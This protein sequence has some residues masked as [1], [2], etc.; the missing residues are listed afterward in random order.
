MTSADEAKQRILAANAAAARA[1]R[2]R[3]ERSG[4]LVVNLISSPGSGKTALLEASA[5]R[6]AGRWRMAAVVGDIATERDAERLRA[7][8]LPARQ[9][10]TGGACH[11]DARM[12]AEA[13]EQ[14]AFPELDLLFVEN[15]GNLVC[16]ASFDLGESFKVVLLSVTE[17]ADKPLKYPG[18]FSKAEVA[19]IT[20]LDLA[21]HLAFDIEAAR[22]E[23]RSLRPDGTLLGLSSKTGEG[24]EEWCELLGERVEARRAALAR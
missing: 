1:L 10:V 9:I 15:V 7:A 19:L 4:T 8:G 22:A 14:A 2:E 12:L 13:L 20:K 17:G 18:I 5:R 23:I 21:P 11:L 3:C 6:L 16:P 24:M